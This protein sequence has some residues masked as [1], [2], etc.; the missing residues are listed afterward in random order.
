MRPASLG[1]SRTRILPTA[2]AIAL[3]TVAVHAQLHPILL[4]W[5]VGSALIQEEEEEEEQ[6]QQQACST[7]TART[8]RDAWRERRRH[9][10]QWMSVGFQRDLLRQT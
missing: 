2:R 8:S 7:T 9:A 1:S 4:T 5:S 10:V 3:A 6:Q